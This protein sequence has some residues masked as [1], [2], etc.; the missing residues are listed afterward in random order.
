MFD[1]EEISDYET[2]VPV[3]KLTRNGKCMYDAF[4]EKVKKD[5]NISHEPDV[6]FAHIED[7]ANHLAPVEK[8]YRKIKGTK[9]FHLYEAK[10]RN[11]R[12]YL[13]HVSE[14]RIII[15]GGWKV[16]QK[17]D[18]LKAISIADDYQAFLKFSNR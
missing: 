17:Q 6:I 5:A 7:V 3:F 10:S 11:L 2:E 15:L 8:K 1:V 14:G 13:L 4:V 12:V 9:K 18:I 16:N